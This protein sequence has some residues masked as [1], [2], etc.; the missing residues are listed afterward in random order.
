MLVVA[1]GIPGQGTFMKIASNRRASLKALWSL[2]ASLAF[3][4]IVPA[5]ADPFF[6]I[7]NA[8][9]TFTGQLTLDPTTPIDPT[10][11]VGCCGYD[12]PSG[13]G[14]FAVSLG[15]NSFS[16]LITVVVAPLGFG[17]YSWFGGGGAGRGPPPAL[18]GISFGS[19]YIDLFLYGSTTSTGSILPQPLSSYTSSSFSIFGNSPDGLYLAEYDG[20]LSSLVQIDSGIF[21]FTGTIVGPPPPGVPGPIAGAGLPGLILASGGLLGWW[22]RRQWTA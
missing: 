17:N 19:G 20:T 12:S 5:Q 1:C 14:T 11:T 3:F 10:L 9:D 13:I 16:E 21:N 4:G 2:C 15:G 8:G 7:V 6:P 22:R 18:N